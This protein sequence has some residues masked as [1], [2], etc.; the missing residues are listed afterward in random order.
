M[1]TTLIDFTRATQSLVEARAQLA[2]VREK[3][4]KAGRAAEWEHAEYRV[5]SAI[6]QTE[7]VRELLAEHS[8]AIAGLKKAG[9]PLDVVENA[10]LCAFRGGMAVMQATVFQ[11]NRFI[12]SL[13][14]SPK[15][16]KH[17][18]TG[19][20]AWLMNGFVLGELKK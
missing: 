6:A 5:S 3:A 8:P 18:V 12:A 2:D 14:K 7:K 20:F 10:A 1:H 15:S 9:V 19:L 17:A 11:T 4:A 16:N 13:D